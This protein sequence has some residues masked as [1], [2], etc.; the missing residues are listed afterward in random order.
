MGFLTVEEVAE[1]C[2]RA[3]RPAILLRQERPASEE[4]QDDAVVATEVPGNT[5]RAP[6]RQPDADQAL[7]AAPPRQRASS[8]RPLELMPQSQPKAELESSPE[9]FGGDNPHSRASSAT[10]SSVC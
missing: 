6:R 8:G 1:L 9:P 3:V 10:F 4:R 7:H 5:G 2:R